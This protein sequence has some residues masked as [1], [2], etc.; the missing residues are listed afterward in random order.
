M[1]P[2]IINFYDDDMVLISTSSTKPLWHKAMQRLKIVFGFRITKT[3]H[4]FLQPP[5]LPI[6]DIPATLKRYLNAVETFTP[7]DD[8]EKTTKYVDQFL[9]DEDK[10]KEIMAFLE[11]KNEAEEN[12][13]CMFTLVDFTAS[14]SLVYIMEPRIKPA[15]TKKLEYFLKLFL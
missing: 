15:L 4:H 8:L 12:W 13:V 11:K 6:P 2:N 9:Q 14:P 1:E 3:T 5:K 10:T 7:S